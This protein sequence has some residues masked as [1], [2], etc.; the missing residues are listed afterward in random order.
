MVAL[1]CDKSRKLHNDSSQ[2]YLPDTR[3]GTARRPMR[4]KR[5]QRHTALCK[6][7]PHSVRQIMVNYYRYGA[8]CQMRLNVPFVTHSAFAER[9]HTIVS[10]YERQNE[11]IIIV[12]Q[13]ETAL[14]RAPAVALQARLAHAASCDV[15][16]GPC[17]VDDRARQ[18]RRPL[19]VLARRA[20]W[21]TLCRDIE[22]LLEH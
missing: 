19:G 2:H 7:I 3:H 20:R 4:S 5:S 1:V 15:F 16:L 10:Y 18:A 22:A 14:R 13:A 21:Y 17:T 6:M 12:R 9:P 8:A 11:I